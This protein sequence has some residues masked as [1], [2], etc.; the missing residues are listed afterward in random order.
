[1]GAGYSEVHLSKQ[2]S[3]LLVSRM[4]LT[5]NSIS[6]MLDNPVDMMIGLPVLATFL[7]NGIS[8]ISNEEIF[9]RLVDKFGKQK[10]TSFCLVI[11]EFYDISCQYYKGTE[12]CEFEYDREWWKNKYEELCQE[13][14]L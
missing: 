10:M 6:D 9:N 14:T 7:I 4:V 2:I 11:S 3:E 1:M 13:V 12:P 5:H 8:V